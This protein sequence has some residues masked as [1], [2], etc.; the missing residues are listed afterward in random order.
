MIHGNSRGYLRRPRWPLVYMLAAVV[1]ALLVVGGGPLAAGNTRAQDE[2]TATDVAEEP[3]V[4]DQP[5]TEETNTDSEQP[6]LEVTEPEPPPVEE[7]EQPP[8]EE[9]E[10]EQPPVEEPAGETDVTLENAATPEIG[11]AANTVPGES[12]QQQSSTDAPPPPVLSYTPAE[13]PG[14][15]PTQGQPELIAHGAFLDYNCTFALSFTSEHLAAADIQLDWTVQ[16]AVDGGWAVQL[17]PPPTDAEVETEWTQAQPVTQFT[18]GG[19]VWEAPSDEIAES[20]DATSELAF[21]L[22]VQRAVCGVDVQSVRLDLGVN[23]SLPNLATGTVEQLGSQPQTFQLTP[24]LVPI[25]EPTVAFIGALD[26]GEV[27]VTTEGPVSPLAPG[28][29]VLTV[30]GLDQACG[31]YRLTVSSTPF[32]GVGDAQPS[33]TP[34]GE[35]GNTDPS[36][37]TLALA[38]IDDVALPDG[39]CAFADG[40][41]IAVVSAGPDAEPVATFTL[42]VSLVLPDQ[43]RAAVFNASLAASLQ[44]VSPEADEAVSAQPEQG[45]GE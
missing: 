25:P 11:D 30:T 29:S 5:A 4:D 9:I 10:S 19:D 7:T 41:D 22:R 34:M 35:T 36:Q 17:L 28:Q 20:L 42:G 43:P 26:F 12:D 23:A 39:N 38:S 1:I 6:P 45:T 44:P 24:E 37:V 32:S 13:Q 27:G 31:D 16:A 2:T 21:G 3:Y 18:Y 14:C 15:V 8:V 40:C 33:E